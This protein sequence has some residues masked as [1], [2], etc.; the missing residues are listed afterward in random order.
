MIRSMTGYAKEEYR[1]ESGWLQWELRSVNHR[2]F[3]VEIRLPGVFRDME[4]EFRNLMGLRI[5]RG[6]VDARLSWRPAE[7]F[8]DRIK[9]NTGL[10]VRVIGYAKVLAEQMRRPASVSPL[11]VM[12]WPGVIEEHSADHSHMSGEV[13]K[14]LHK[15]VDSL[16]AAQMSEGKKLKKAIESRCTGMDKLVHTFRARTPELREQAWSRMR[17]RLEAI[18]LRVDAERL[19]KEV[20][21]L[22]MRHDISEELDRLEAHLGALRSALKATEPAGKRVNFLLQE[23]GREANT[24]AAKS[25]DARGTHEAV[26]MRVIVEQM[27]EQAQNI[28]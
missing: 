19:E 17:E 22:L 2:H 25:G 14:L 4:P 27:R 28:L 23:I 15:A 26:D 12:R 5:S 24:L 1:S 11:D 6:H 7:K 21:L 3:D 8:A 16:R 20:A 10:A 18:K 9:V 13:R